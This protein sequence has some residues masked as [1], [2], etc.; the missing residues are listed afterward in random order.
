MRVVNQSLAAAKVELVPPNPY[1]YVFI[2]A[3][4]DNGAVVSEL[5][6]ADNLATL[7]E[8]PAQSLKRAV[9]QSETRSLRAD[10]SRL[11]SV[12]AVSL[13]EAILFA[14]GSLHRFRARGAGRAAR[15][16]TLL[17]VE[18]ESPAAAESLLSRAEFRKL[19]GAV[20]ERS[21]V[22][23]LLMATNIK[24]IQG[25]DRTRGGA[26]LFNFFFAEDPQLLQD[27]WDHTAGWWLAHGDMRNSE[28]MCPVGSCEYALI[29]N[30]RWE[31]AECA[32]KAFRSP[33]YWEFVLANIEACK[34][35][36]MPTLYRWLP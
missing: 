8:I 23:K 32:I 36:A 1:G 11:A 31:D 15:Y 17:V 35:S 28:L 24:R 3:E 16:D 20:Q 26:F 27:V 33:D 19:L 6:R 21:A 30:A 5:T 12:R 9:L 4:V 25:V 10:L 13:F 7:P 2:M 34:A 14:P 29:N 18:T 22:A